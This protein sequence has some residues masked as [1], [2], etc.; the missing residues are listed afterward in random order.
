VLVAQILHGA[1]L[2]SPPARDLASARQ[3][4]SYQPIRELALPTVQNRHGVRSPIDAFVV[5]RLEANGLALS[6]PTDRR[7]LI[8]RAYYDLIGLPPTFDEIESFRKDQASDAFAQLVDR[9]L[10]SPRY[11]ERWGRHWLDVARYAETKDLVLLFGKDRLQPYAYTYRDYVIRAFNLDTPFDQ[12]VHEQLAA[13]QMEPKAEPWRLAALG[14]L[15][16][17]RLYDNNPHDQIDDQIDTV[18]RAFLGL[19]VSC[20]RCHDHKYDAISTEDY[21]SLYGVFASS[22]RPYDLPLIE[23]PQKVADGEAFE[24]KLAEARKKLQDHIDAE[25]EKLSEVARQR[26]GAYLIR[27]ATTPPDL[28]ETASFFLSLTPDDLRPVLVSRWRGYVEKY[29][30]KGDPVFGLWAALMALPEKDFAGRAAEVVRQNRRLPEA[31]ALASARRAPNP[32]VLEAFQ[33]ATPT[34]KAEVARVYGELLQRVYE[35]SQPSSAKSEATPQSEAERELVGILTSKESPAYFP[36]SQTPQHM[37]RPDKD[38]YGGLVRELDKLAAYA[39]NPPPARAMVVADASELH[40]PYVFVRGSAARPGQRVPRA[41]LSVLAGGERKPFEHGSGRL[42]LAKAITSPEN[43]LTARVLVNRVWMH[44]FGEPLVGSPNDFGVRSDR[45]THPE[46]LDYLAWKFMHEGWSLKQLHRLIMNSSV[47]QQASTGG[48][49]SLAGSLSA[50]QTPPS[51][52]PDNKLLWRFHRRRLDLESMRDT[53]L[54]ISGR[55][56]LTMGGRSVDVSSDPLN[57]RRTVYGLVDRQDLPALFR[58]FDF[59]VP[60]Q[61]VERRPRT[62]VP[63]QALFAMNSPFVLEQAKALAAKANSSLD[64]AGNVAELYRSILGRLPE[65]AEVERATRYLGDAELEADA[66][67]AG[68]LRPWEQ[69][70]QALLMSN[71]LAFVE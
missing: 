64:A 19:T 3:H 52:D 60:D 49:R 22:E 46:L 25:Y 18:S 41:F 30:R 53:L 14:F 42:D 33:A 63:Q 55:L 58:A 16:L 69:F 2:P 51:E 11:G 40:D 54:L 66:N 39:T 48:V 68:R 50:I 45:P 35:S 34:N 47:Y 62:S 31:D 56:D 26:A 65:P 1:E 23:D 5:A 10:A 29:A 71:E 15:T 44:H 13:D 8:R 17:G 37:S 6:P 27:V 61:S 21:Y 32:L 24:K 70:A 20:A 57:R 43:P 38:K 28:S 12:F 7:T 59:A 36:K 4:W 9:L 67:T